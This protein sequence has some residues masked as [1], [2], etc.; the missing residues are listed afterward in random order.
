[1]TYAVKEVD[2]VLHAG[3][4]DHFNA[5]SDYFPPLE[6][7]HY[8]NG[9][10]WVVYAKGEPIAFAGLVPFEPFEKWIGYCKRCL[11]TPD[12]Y[13]RGLQQHLLRIRIEKAK[14]LNYRM[15]VSDCAEANTHSAANF[16]KMG[17]RCITPEQF[18]AGRE[19]LYWALDL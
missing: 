3:I 8:A 12:H 6:P 10:W 11:V 19:M 16:R 2:G 9:W 13:G 1:M 14:R 7:Q 18:W 5:M 4:L 17:F 15:V